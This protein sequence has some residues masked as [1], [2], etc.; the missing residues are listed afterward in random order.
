MKY[1]VR[2][3]VLV[4]KMLKLTGDEQY[5]F[6]LK[7]KKNSEFI[8][9]LSLANNNLIHLPEKL[10]EDTPRPS[11]IPEDT[12]RTFISLV[13]DVVGSPFSKKPQKALIDFIIG[14]GREVEE[15]DGCDPLSKY[16]YAMV[17]NHSIRIDTERLSKHIPQVAWGVPYEHISSFGY[18]KLPCVVQGYFKGAEIAVIKEGEM[19][20][21]VTKSGQPLMG[22]DIYIPYFKA[23]DID[24]TFNIILGEKN[25]SRYKECVFGT[26]PKA[27][28]EPLT[29]IDYITNE[30]LEDRLWKLSVALLNVDTDPR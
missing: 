4:W 12:H 8:A 23:L 11:R 5:R 13:G 21:V 14:D 18:P 27:A 26:P 7:H 22:F 24:G 20:V 17:V 6:I 29:I 3:V 9:L 2:P 25:T 1:K 28:I 15:G 19:V 30:K 16:I 10:P